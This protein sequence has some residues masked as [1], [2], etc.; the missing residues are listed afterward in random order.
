MSAAFAKLNPFSEPAVFLKD[1]TEEKAPSEERQRHSADH[2][3]RFYGLS[4][5]RYC[6]SVRDRGGRPRVFRTGKGLAASD[7]ALGAFQVG[8]NRRDWVARLWERIIEEGPRAAESY[9][10]EPA[11]SE[12]SLATPNLLP[13]VR[14]LGPIRPFTFL[15]A[16]LLEPSADPAALRSELVPFVGP[17]D[18]V[19]RAALMALPGQRSLG[20]VL[21]D[22]I[23]H[24]DHKYTFDADGLAVRRHVLVRKR[25][26]TALGKEANR[27]EEARVLGQSAVSGRA[28]RYADADPYSG[29]ATEV[30]RR[31]GVSR[32]TVFNRRKWNRR[33]GAAAGPHDRAGGE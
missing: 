29:S 16:R 27:I 4:A 6:L 10:G 31:I 20:S 12:F 18:S 9:V 25:I 17:E 13:R 11:T 22:F 30:A 5:K 28:K 3:P 21:E 7:H 8:K 2:A 33:L 1:E 32:R 15:T 14:E 19:R 24:R 23:A 26:L